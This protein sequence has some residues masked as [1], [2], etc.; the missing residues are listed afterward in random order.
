MKEATL[1][2]LESGERDDLPTS[3]IRIEPP[4]SSRSRLIDQIQTD[5][6]INLDRNARSA[7]HVARSN[8]ALLQD[9]GRLD[10]PCGHDD[11]SAGRSGVGVGVFVSEF[12]AGSSG[13]GR[14]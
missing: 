6:Q 2:H 12:D 11:F 5:R 4:I 10:A 7:Q 14:G 3:S 1:T 13:G 8:T 9:D